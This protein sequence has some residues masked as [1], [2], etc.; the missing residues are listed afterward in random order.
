MN[1]Y[2]TILLAAMG[3]L[4]VAVELR[5]QDTNVY[6]Q[7]PPPTILEALEN[8]PDQLIIKGT[9]TVGT[10]STG[11]RGD[12]SGVQGGHSRERRPEG[13]RHPGG[14]RRQWAAGRQH[15]GGL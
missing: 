2:K 6:L 10:V 4:M 12:S 11:G 1:P 14:H 8:T 7:L 9:E 15:G 5:A 13:T 3:G